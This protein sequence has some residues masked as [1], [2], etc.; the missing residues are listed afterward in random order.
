VKNSW[1]ILVLVGVLFWFHNYFSK[2]FFL[3]KNYGVSFGMNGVVLI[4]LNILFI[5]LFLVLSIKKGRFFIL[6]LGG[7]LVNLIDRINFGY[8]RDYWNFLHLG[9]YNNINDWIIG[10]G[11]LFCLIDLFLWKKSK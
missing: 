6:I 1:F 10:L 4:V 7:A 11:V 3:I 2:S 9:L 5:L 8:V